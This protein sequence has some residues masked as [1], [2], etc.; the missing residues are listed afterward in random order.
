MRASN[1]PQKDNFYVKTRGCVQDTLAL[2]YVVKN[3]ANCS[4]QMD[5]YL[6][7]LVEML[8]DMIDCE[9]CSIYLYDRQMDELYCKIITGGT[10]A[11]RGGPAK[12]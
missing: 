8:S 1:A 11:A 10:L 5:F 7:S 2:Y 3:I 4:S 9:R 12:R 6:P